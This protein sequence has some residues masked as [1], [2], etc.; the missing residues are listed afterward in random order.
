MS[1]LFMP[2]SL[3]WFIQVMIVEVFQS[4]ITLSEVRKL[5]PGKF[6][7]I[8]PLD[9]SHKVSSVHIWIQDLFHLKFL[10]RVRFKWYETQLIWKRVIMNLLYVNDVEHIVDFP[11]RKQF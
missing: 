9:Q 10:V 11:I 7:E 1:K 4:L 8:S 2:V 6:I 5:M 3:V